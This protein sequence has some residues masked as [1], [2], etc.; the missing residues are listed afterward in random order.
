MKIHIATGALMFA[1]FLT[2][3]AAQDKPAQQTNPAGMTSMMKDCLMSVRGAEIAVADTDGGVALTITT[4]SGDVAELRER[5][6]RM[7]A[8]HDV[9]A[10]LETIDNGA[11]VTL[12]P[13]DPAGLTAL[14]KQVREHVDRMAKGG[15]CEQ[16]HQM[17]QGMKG[18]MKSGMMGKMGATPEPAAE[19]KKAEPEI[20]HDAHHPGEEKK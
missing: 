10:K 13:K 2:S 3:V 20:D 11:R 1:A 17:M 16:M 18:G 8:M 4:G 12:T 9:Q 15:G 19:T 7:L 6:K 14:R 5:V